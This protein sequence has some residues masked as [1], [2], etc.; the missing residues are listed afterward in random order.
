MKVREHLRSATLDAM[1]ENHP[2]QEE[3]AFLQDEQRE[4]RKAL[5]SLEA[6]RKD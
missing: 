1:L 5:P 2:M 4:L 3:L 6:K